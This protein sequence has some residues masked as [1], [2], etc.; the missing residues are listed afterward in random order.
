MTGFARVTCLSAVAMALAGCM[1]VSSLKPV[2]PP[3]MAAN[4]SSLEGDYTLHGE[5]GDILLTV[6]RRDA[7]TYDAYL[8]KPE[9]PYTEGLAVEFNAVPLRNGDFA[10]QT[11]CL[12]S[13]DDGG[14]GKWKHLEPENPYWT[15]AA[16]RP[17]GDYWLG[18]NLS[19]DAANMLAAKYGQNQ[20]KDGIK[21]AGLAPDRAT[22]FFQDWLR[23]QLANGGDEILPIQR[24]LHPSTPDDAETMKHP[25]AC[26]DIPAK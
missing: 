18:F 26:R 9:A 8:F 3:G 14:D 4:R 22:A 11:V 21:L 1:T 10:I 6:V 23:A 12:A 17:H 16:A 24:K 5:K 13:L 2:F 20:D 25:V 15:L 7:A 19:D